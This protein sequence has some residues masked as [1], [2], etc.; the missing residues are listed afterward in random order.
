MALDISS[1]SCTALLTVSGLLGPVKLS[2]WSADDIYEVE[3]VETAETK[4]G[5]DYVMS[6]GQIPYITKQT[7]SFMA[8]SASVRVFLQWNAANTAAVKSGNS[9]FTGILTLL[10]PSVSLKY[11]QTG[12]VLKKFPPIIGAGKT[13]KEQK[14]SIDWE[15]VIAVPA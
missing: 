14:F 6:S 4:M 1:V 11:T 10:V 8:S 5:L 15:S 2:G 9:P 3:E 13:L 7:F 12:G